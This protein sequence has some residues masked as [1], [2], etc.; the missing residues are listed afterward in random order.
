MTY[1]LGDGTPSRV[2]VPSA[3][4]GSVLTTAPAAGLAVLAVS[5]TRL[6]EPLEL[7]TVWLVEP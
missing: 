2:K 5:A 4:I 6:V 7:A 3:P 1:T